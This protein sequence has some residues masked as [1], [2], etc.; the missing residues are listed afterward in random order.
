V[1]DEARGDVSGAN[2]L[3]GD[4]SAT[5]VLPII[6]ETLHL[7]KR[8]VEKGG[9]RLTK[10][11]STHDEIVD[12]ALVSSE[13]L[14]ERREVGELVAGDVAPPIRVEGNA[15]I[16][17]IV[18]EILVTEKRLLLV[19]EVSVRRVDTTYHEPQTITLRKE[20]IVVEQ[21]EDRLTPSAKQP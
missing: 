6:E 9:L 15:T 13:V 16:Y 8:R 21:M 10:T 11:V 7:E 2:V 4:A 20:E 17:P 5:R 14:V 12:E 19:A 3:A 1:N 18:K